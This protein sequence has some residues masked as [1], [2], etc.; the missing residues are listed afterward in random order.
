MEGNAH[1]FLR[2]SG[3]IFNGLGWVALVLG[4]VATLVILIGGGGPDAP[5]W[6]GIVGIVVGAIYFLIFKTIGGVIQLLLDIESRIK[7]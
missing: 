1:R 2:N 4:A 7:P 6:A 5:R 3:R